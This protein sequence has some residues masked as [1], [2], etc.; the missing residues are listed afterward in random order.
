MIRD[1]HLL[2]VKQL[3]A[4][5]EALLAEGELYRHTLLEEVKSLRLHSLRLDKQ[6]RSFSRGVGSL[7]V[8]APLAVSLFGSRSRKVVPER[9]PS[10]WRRLLGVG[11]TGWRLYR[12]FAPV[13]QSLWHP[14][15][16][17][18]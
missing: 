17:V 15:R 2:A 16:A 4:R 6:A 5:K 3:E 14:R 7:V 18:L 13:V 8:L 10:R 1:E 11:L 9:T 12:R